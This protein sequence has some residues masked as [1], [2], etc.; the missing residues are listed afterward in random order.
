MV[1][2][3]TA[4][5]ALCHAIPVSSL[6]ARCARERQNILC[7]AAIDNSSARKEANWISTSSRTAE[8]EAGAAMSGHGL[9]EYVVF[10][11][12]H[13]EAANHAA[14]ARIVDIDAF[15]ALH[16]KQRF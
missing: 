5:P 13:I 11:A 10:E 1:A 16:Q 12:G 14:G 4:M 3:L 7:S 2:R 6:A 9:D 15:A 8:R